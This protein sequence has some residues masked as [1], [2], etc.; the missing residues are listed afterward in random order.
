MVYVRVHQLYVATNFFSYVELI[1]LV[2]S[3]YGKDEGIHVINR[4]CLLHRGNS[5]LRT[6]RLPSQ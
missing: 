3:L 2:V 6:V 5:F 4:G 1:F